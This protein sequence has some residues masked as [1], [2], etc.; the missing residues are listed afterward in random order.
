MRMLVGAAIVALAVPTTTLVAQAGD[1]VFGTWVLN[2]GKSK[3]EPGP[4]PKSQ[5]R[6]Y[7][8]AP[9]GFKFTADGVDAAGKKTHVEFTAAFDGKYHA[10][11][12]NATA[13]SIMVKRIDANTT[14]SVLKKGAKEVSHNTRV[15]SKDGK[16]LTAT[17][18]GTTA[19]GK[20]STSTE[21]YDKK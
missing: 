13:D 18:K 10:M 1:P 14:E 12:G 21:V 16:T 3:Y 20:P 17:V 15:V 8:A 19:A 11:T 4:A 6:T 5:T 9:N 7:A 2:V